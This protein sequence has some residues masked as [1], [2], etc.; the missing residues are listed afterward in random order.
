MS[1]DKELKRALKRLRDKGVEDLMRKDG[2]KVLSLMEVEH[3]TSGK[4][5]EEV[6]RLVD[7]WMSESNKEHYDEYE[8]QVIKNSAG[9]FLE[10]QYMTYVRLLT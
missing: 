4:F 5:N 9:K 1:K 2:D 7:K 3:L 8:S 10:I 6:K